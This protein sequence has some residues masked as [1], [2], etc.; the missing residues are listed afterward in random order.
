M[1]AG[2]EKQPLR[3]G[4]T[5]MLK[6]LGKNRPRHSKYSYRGGKHKETQ[7]IASQVRALL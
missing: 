3:D 6:E 2:A 1:R 4:L 7:S 5:A